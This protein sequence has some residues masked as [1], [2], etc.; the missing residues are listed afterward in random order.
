MLSL[1][2]QLIVI[3]DIY[4]FFLH[5]LLDEKPKGIFRHLSDSQ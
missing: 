2:F 1:F 4:V 5:S 3:F